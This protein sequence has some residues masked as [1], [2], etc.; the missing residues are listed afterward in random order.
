[1]KKSTK[2]F[3]TEVIE[4]LALSDNIPPFDE[5]RKGTQVI[6]IDCVCAEAFILQEKGL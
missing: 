6:M 1:M 2:I 3:N 5:Q 4:R